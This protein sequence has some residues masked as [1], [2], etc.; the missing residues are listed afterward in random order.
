LQKRPIQ[1]PVTREEEEEEEEEREEEE[2]EEEEREE[3][4]REEEER[5]EEE[6]ALLRRLAG[7]RGMNKINHVDKMN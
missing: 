2:R 6:R 5:E 1:A 3:E 4:E 7:G